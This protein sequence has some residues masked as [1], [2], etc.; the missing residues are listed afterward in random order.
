VARP[1]R[2]P[3]RGAVRKP[4]RKPPA[5]RRLPTVSL[6]DI[7]AR[8]SRALPWLLASLTLL[9][10]MAGLIYLPRMLDSYP[11]QAVTVEGVKDARR[12]QQVQLTLSTLVSGENFF[13]VSLDAL[14]QEVSALSWVAE[15]EVRRRWPG[16]LVLKVEERVPVAV[17]NDELL[18]ASSG[19]PFRGLDKYSVDAL[20]RLSGPALR[21]TEVMGYYHSMSRILQEIGLGIRNVSVNA[22][23]TAELTL[24]NGVVLVVDREQYAHKLRR[25]VQLYRTVLEA[26]NRA[27]ARVDL[28]YADGMAVTWGQDKAPDSKPEK[29]V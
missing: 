6:T 16:Q 10:V 15:T 1:A 26:D 21:L 12:Q 9:I 4:A 8:L 7:M 25:F 24:D 18:V 13:S 20:P 3:A 28:R 5:A 29:R 22:R 27:L 23:L 11:L 19:E 14:H 2:K 17:W